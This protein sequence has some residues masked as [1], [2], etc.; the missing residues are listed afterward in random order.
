MKKISNSELVLMEVLWSATEPLDRHEI[1]KAVEELENHEP[2]SLATVSTFISRL[3][4][5]DVIAYV[6]K[7]KMYHYYPLVGRMEYFRYVIDEKLHESMRLKID[8]VLAL[9]TGHQKDDEA[10]KKEVRKFIDKLSK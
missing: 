8:E 5:K 2:W 1:A 4:N 3:C 9:Y 6:K 7:D 10:C